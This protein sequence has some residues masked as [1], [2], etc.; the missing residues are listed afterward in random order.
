MIEIHHNEP[1]NWSDLLQ[2]VDMIAVLNVKAGD[3]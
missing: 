2:I 1:N 3:T